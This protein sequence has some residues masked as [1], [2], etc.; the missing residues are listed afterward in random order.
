MSG[1]DVRGARTTLLAGMLM[2]LSLAGTSAHAADAAQPRFDLR[3]VAEDAFGGGD[4]TL[5]PDGRRFVI[6]SRRG[7]NWDLWIYDLEQRTWK[8]VT[9]HEAD[10]HEAQWSP[11]GR[12]LV[13]TSTREGSKDVWTLGL[14]DR[15]LKRLTSAPEDEEY[16]AWSPDGKQIVY[17]GGP[18][19]RR[20]F[21][22]VPATGGAPR[23]VTA[24]PG[25]IGACAFAP[26]GKA[27]ICHGYSTGSGD[28]FLLPLDGGAP[29]SLTSGSA[30]DYKPRVAPHQGWFAFSR[31]EDG[32]SAIWLQQFGGAGDAE[33]LL[34]PP[35]PHEDRWPT[36]DATGTSLLFHRFVERGTAVKQLE[37]ATGAVR[38]LSDGEQSVGQASFDPAA[39]RVVYSAWVDGR[40][41]LRLRELDAG[42]TR[43]LDTRPGQA[44][45]PRWSPDGKRIAFAYREGARWELATIGADGTGL[46]VWTRNFV[47]VHALAGPLDWS[48]DGQRLLFKADTAP[49]ESDIFVLDTRDGTFRNLTNDEWFDE[50]PSWGPG[51]G[52]VVFMS[53]RGGNW[54][55][56]LFRLDTHGGQIEPLTA[57]DYTEKNFPRLAAS[58]VVTF[59]M[60][61]EHGVERLAQR[62]ADGTL[63]LL[64][65]GGAHARW[66]SHSSDG[67]FL[68]FTEV[69]RKVE[70]WLGRNV[71]VNGEPA[72]RPSVRGSEP[73]S[74]GHATS[75]TAL[76]Q[77]GSD[78][79]W[80][81]RARQTPGARLLDSPKN[82]H[83]R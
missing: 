5:A 1:A 55:W 48:P 82:L 60:Y 12:S 36:W 67:R 22:V 64:A 57:A 38:T 58:G 61:D 14:Q 10:D 34:T 26:D 51:A 83:H 28:V 30:W 20:D 15:A 37:V 44:S 80:P 78:S 79:D 24:R 17:T 76:S 49:F 40:Q 21:F 33:L 66:P 75:V 43:T 31:S 42:T 50:A 35:S 18:W 19:K 70:Y 6:S 2:G 54:T 3:L 69:E 41:V 4:A 68:L 63:H 62:R 59:S 13:F 72:W 45:F 29:V 32:P 56:G 16:P 9:D 73:S 71:F 65:T 52:S 27:L 39:K 53:T 74:G 8:Q 46:E 25:H 23:A 47:G 7:G 81:A 11:D 77:S